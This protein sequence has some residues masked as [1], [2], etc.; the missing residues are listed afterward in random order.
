MPTRSFLL[1]D[2][3]REVSAIAAADDHTLACVQD[4]KGALFFF[5][6]D[7][8]RV[9]RRAKFGPKGDYEGLAKVG[10]DYW[11]LR[12]DGLLL[13]LVA[14]ADRYEIAETLATGL[15]VKEFEGLAVDRA[16]N[17]F[18]LAPKSLAKE[19]E[20]RELRPLFAFD[21]AT[22]LAAKEP[23]ITLHL[24]QVLDA[25]RL[26]GIA[27]P[28]RLSKRGKEKPAVRL[29]FAE[30]AVHPGTGELWL[31]SAG[32]RALLVVDRNGQFRG[33]HFFP[34]EEMPQPEAATFL[35]NGHLVLGSEG[36][37]GPAVLR[38]YACVPQPR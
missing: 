36:G 8:G 20:E 3:L 7:Q 31:L 25:A 18:V 33:M 6:L 11:V 13:R 30:V 2:D 17:R 27:V 22:R 5:D 12:S 16:A 1:P 23:L 21:L 32:D 29:F 15:G 19:T 26:Q 38:V 14:T 35:P 34:A 28:T 37:G 4:E 9:L 10:D 24:D